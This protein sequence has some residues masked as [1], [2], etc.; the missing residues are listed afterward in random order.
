MVALIIGDSQVVMYETERAERR[1]GEGEREE[2]EVPKGCRMMRLGGA[3]LYGSL[4]ITKSEA[5]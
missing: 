3:Y 5:K 1:E 4:R 2:K